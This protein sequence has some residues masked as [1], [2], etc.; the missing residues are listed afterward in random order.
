MSLN[1]VDMWNDAEL[2]SKLEVNHV[3][4]DK[5]DTRPLSNPEKGLLVHQLLVSLLADKMRELS[6]GGLATFVMQALETEA[7]VASEVGGMKQAEDWT[8]VIEPGRG[9]IAR[10]L[11]RY[12][13]IMDDLAPW[14]DPAGDAL[15][16]DTAEWLNRILAEHAVLRQGVADNTS[17]CC[18]STLTK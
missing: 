13:A 5:G 15:N 7:I 4:H 12:V 1:L 2:E 18:C 10:R 8:K 14:L 17:G 6:E 9:E 11:K 3:M 16:K